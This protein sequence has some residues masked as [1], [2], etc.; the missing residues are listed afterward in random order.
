VLC[1]LDARKARKR[2]FLWAVAEGSVDRADWKAGTFAVPSVP[3]LSASMTLEDCRRFYAEEVQLLAG[4]SNPALI[5]AFEN[6]P[7][8]NF[9]GPGPWHVGISDMRTGGVRYSTTPDADP[10]RVYHNVPIALDKT[11]DLNNGQPATVAYWIDSLALKPA[12]RIFHLGC[13]VGYFTAIMAQVIGPNGTI[14][15]G[16]VEPELAVRARTNLAA[17]K[18]VTVRSGDGALVDPGE[19]DAM[20]I[21]AGVTHPLPLW[22][23]RLAEGGRLILPLTIPVTAHLGK[24]LMTQIE[25]RANGYA[26]QLVGFVA[27]YTCSSARN[28]QLEPL[29]GQGMATGALMRM[30]SLRR[31]HH[32]AG[33]ACA[34]H[35][36][37]FCI[38]TAALPA[39]V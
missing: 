16:E 12:E 18:N 33:D 38:S 11:R 10:R 24:G 14:V 5:R 28:P 25:R 4:L 19:C 37:D 2:A 17:W 3:Y 30:Q 35:G 1:S 6:V 23:D 27:I 20:M 8:E 29:L 13:G 39:P 7:R 36:P 9:L 22:L 32:E 26:A 21:N 15:A 31:D 34:L